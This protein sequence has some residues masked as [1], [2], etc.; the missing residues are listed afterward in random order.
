MPETWSGQPQRPAGVGAKTAILTLLAVVGCIPLGIICDFMRLSVAETL[1]VG[2]L[3]TGIV[4]TAL[5]FWT[6]P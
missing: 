2:A 6:M 1:G 5:H 4:I 3:W